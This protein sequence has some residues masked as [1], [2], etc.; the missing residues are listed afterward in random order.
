MDKGWV[1]RQL[2]EAEELIDE[3]GGAETVDKRRDQAIQL[4]IYW[5]LENL[6]V[7]VAP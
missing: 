2:V 5:A 3:S 4:M 1:K 7:K 6:S